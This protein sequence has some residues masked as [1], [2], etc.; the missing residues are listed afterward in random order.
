[1]TPILFAFLITL[2]LI[3]IFRLKSRRIGSN[4]F[5]QIGI[6][7]LCVSFFYFVLVF[8]SPFLGLESTPVRITTTNN[9]DEKI[10]VYNITVYDHPVYG[11]MN[12]FVYKGKNINVGGTSTTMIEYDGADEFWTIGLDESGKVVFLKITN[13]HSISE[14]KFNIDKIRIDDQLKANLANADIQIFNKN[15]LTEDIL[16]TINIF[17]IL[18]LVIEILTSKPTYHSL[19]NN[20]KQ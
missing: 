14:Y 4:Q 11:N 13:S 6:I 17:L 8:I 7:V 19:T 2:I 20:N 9:L 3:L 18:L 1:M 15:K 12:R 16:I 5:R 10:K